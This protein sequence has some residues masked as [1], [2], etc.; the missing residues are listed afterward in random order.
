MFV[1]WLKWYG[2]VIRTDEEC[3]GKTVM[4]VMMMMMMDVYGR[5]TKGRPKRRLMDS[6][7]ASND[8]KRKL[9]RAKGGRYVKLFSWM[10]I[11]KIVSE[12]NK[13]CD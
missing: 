5:R 6:V 4:M 7:S 10:T 12:G 9:R 1:W 2:H 13:L 8:A 3:V 11:I